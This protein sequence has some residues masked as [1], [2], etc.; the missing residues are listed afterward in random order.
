MCDSSEGTMCKTCGAPV[1]DGV[2]SGC[3]EPADKCNCE[4]VDQME[5]DEELEEGEVEEE[6][7]EEFDDDEEEYI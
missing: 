5:D 3:W 4:P 6:E 2:C 7:E 1:E